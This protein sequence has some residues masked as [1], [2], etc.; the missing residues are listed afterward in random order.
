MMNVRL[1]SALLGLLIG[2]TALPIGAGVG[3]GFSIEPALTPVGYASFGNSTS[4]FASGSTSSSASLIVGAGG[5][6]VAIFVMSSATP[7]VHVGGTSATQER[8]YSG[9]SVG[10]LWVFLAVSPKAASTSVY[11]NGTATRVWSAEEVYHLAATSP[12]DS[13]EF[14]SGCHTGAIG[15]IT[16]SSLTF[17]QGGEIGLLGVFTSEA[18]TTAYTFSVG[19]PGTTVSS[20]PSTTSGSAELLIAQVAI[21]PL[22]FAPG[23]QSFGATTTTQS[24][25]WS[26]VGVPLELSVPAQPVSFAATVDASHHVH[27][28]WTQPAGPS[29]LNYTV[30]A[31]KNGHSV[32]AY[33]STG[34]S[35]PGYVYSSASSG[36]EYQ[37]GVVAW[38]A[39]GPTLPIYSPAIA[40]YTTNAVVGGATFGNSAGTTCYHVTTCQVFVDV[41]S[42][43]SLLIFAATSTTTPSIAVALPAGGTPAQLTSFTTTSYKDFVYFS[44]APAAGWTTVYENTSVSTIGMSI[45]AVAV[46]GVAASPFDAIGN[47]SYATGTSFAG[48]KTPSSSVSATRAGE[49]DV[50][51]GLFIG[52]VGGS[53]QWTISGSSDTIVAQG[54]PNLW[55]AYYN[56]A[57]FAAVAVAAS[58]S[59]SVGA[60]S[61][62]KTLVNY[63]SIALFQAPPKAPGGLALVV[64]TTATIEVSWTASP[65]TVLNYTVEFGSSCLALSID[66]S[67]GNLTVYNITGLSPSQTICVAIVA[68]NATGASPSGAPLTV[69]TKAQGG[70]GG[71]AVGAGPDVAALVA[72]GV[73]VASLAVAIR[74]SLHRRAPRPIRRSNH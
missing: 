40:P 69:E 15:S 61:N 5:A 26:Y 54:A 12:Y 43:Q 58:G 65:G 68:W 16:P 71:A 60:S 7:T 74:P 27:L 9:C 23:S 32:G 47:A 56:A 36:S 50:F 6:D 37:F 70:G 13:T 49:I 30:S 72:F 18:S 39:H 59:H 46:A 24:T 64:A 28:S 51:L 22:G 2:A 66:R 14:T 57:T 25:S 20:L 1:A 63:A 17:A 38:G 62:N 19:S 4:G 11:V 33:A 42:G 29:A 34:S 35:S 45:T 10:T 44:S 8:E 21:S 55:G 52:A 41:G 67:V 73:L 31:I 48:I 53:I 3:A